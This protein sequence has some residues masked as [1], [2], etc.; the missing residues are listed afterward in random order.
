M[1]AIFGVTVY[2]VLLLTPSR[3]FNKRLCMFR[4]PDSIR[5][6]FNKPHEYR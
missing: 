4:K 1:L 2:L 3:Y 6:N 5:Y